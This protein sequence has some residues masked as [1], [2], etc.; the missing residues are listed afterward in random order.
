MRCYRLVKRNYS[1]YFTLPKKI[2]HFRQS[3]GD[4]F[5]TVEVKDGSVIYQEIDKNTKYIPHGINAVCPTFTD[6]STIILLP[7]NLQ[8]NKNSWFELTHEFENLRHRFT[9]S[10][11]HYEP[12]EKHV[13]KKREQTYLQRKIN[14]VEKNS[15]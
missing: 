3:W 2:T 11:V 1:Y 7:S 8:L 4:K 9:F 10:P 13:A 15:R 6:K 12:Q 5:F 14:E